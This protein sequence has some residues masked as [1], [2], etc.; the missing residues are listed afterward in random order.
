MSQK[1]HE[2]V[3]IGAHKPG[4]HDYGVVRFF[5]GQVSSLMNSSIPAARQGV[6]QDAGSAFRTTASR[7]HMLIVAHSFLLNL[8]RAH[9]AS[10][11]ASRDAALQAAL[12][13]LD[14]QQQ[15]FDLLGEVHYK[16]FMLSYHSVDAGIYLAVT[17]AKYPVP[18]PQTARQIDIALQRTI[19]RLSWM[20]PRNA[21]AEGGVQILRR[22]LRSSEQQ[23]TIR[24]ESPPS[25][26][27]H[28]HRSF[29]SLEEDAPSVQPTSSRADASATLLGDPS[30][31]PI[32][33]DQSN[34]GLFDMSI[35][36]FDNLDWDRMFAAITDADYT[37]DTFLGEFGLPPNSPR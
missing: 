30:T 36:D 20:S 34:D 11:Q 18:D 21:L 31:G 24:P 9:S 25:A 17:T 15:L 8:H 23:Q 16:I 3:S 19:Q 26:Q 6:A 37:M 35:P 27:R 12:N 1:G 14:A 7:L 4:F 2:V 5:D 13:I 10:H 33:T 32:D 29:A 22:C 28:H